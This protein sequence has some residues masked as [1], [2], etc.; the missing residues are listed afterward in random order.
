M[1][2]NFGTS[3]AGRLARPSRHHHEDHLST[4]KSSFHRRQIL[5][6]FTEIA[7]PLFDASQPQHRN[8][9]RTLATLR[10][11]LLPKLLSGELSVGGGNPPE[12]PDSSNRRNP[13]S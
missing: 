7:E 4:C 2:P 9:S 1:Q 3:A 10:D 5:D 8:Q 6:A 12:L 13:K 11:T